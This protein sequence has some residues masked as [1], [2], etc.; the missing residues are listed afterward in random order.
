LKT[1]KSAMSNFNFSKKEELKAED[2]IDFDEEAF[3]PE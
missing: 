1:N 3:T 2:K